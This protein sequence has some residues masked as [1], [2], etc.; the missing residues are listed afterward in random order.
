MSKI[1]GTEP[2][3]MFRDWLKGKISKKFH[4]KILNF[5]RSRLEGFCWII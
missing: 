5:L 4:R 1:S 3:R 2:D